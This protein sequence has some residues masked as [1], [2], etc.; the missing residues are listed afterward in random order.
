MKKTLT[1][2][3]RWRER[4]KELGRKLRQI[5]LTDEELKKLRDMLKKMRG[6]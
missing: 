4:Q 6:K 5:W 3:E 2:Q 1:K